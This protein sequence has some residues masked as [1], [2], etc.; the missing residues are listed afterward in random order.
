M[1]MKIK[2]IYIFGFI[3]IIFSIIL[4]L[5]ATLFFPIKEK[6]KIKKGICVLTTSQYL[7]TN[8]DN[9]DVSILFFDSEGFINK[10][11]IKSIRCSLSGTYNQKDIS[12][13]GNV[14]VNN[15]CSYYTSYNLRANITLNDYNKSINLT[16]L[17]LESDK[18]TKIIEIGCIK[19]EKVDGK[20]CDSY[21]AVLGVFLTGSSDNFSYEIS[22]NSEK[23]IQINTL[24]FEI[25]NGTAFKE[26]NS[27]PI[28]V[29]SGEK[30]QKSF[31]FEVTDSVYHIVLKP[32]FI[33]SYID[34]PNNNHLI[35]SKAAT[36]YFNGFSQQEAIDYINNNII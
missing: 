34:E 25:Y 31:Q 17:I 2:K 5:F 6:D 4:Y 18:G 26:I 23:D 10:N 35:V 24:P 36:Y 3:L 9:I 16:K 32:S 30:L 27:I 14:E 12:F 28:T 8:Q 21:D 29:K 19:I 22:N 1:S 20:Y 11:D 15:Y 33:L 7:S 13:I